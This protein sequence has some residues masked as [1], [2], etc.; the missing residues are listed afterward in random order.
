MTTSSLHHTQGVRG[1]LHQK[2]EHTAEAEIYHLH[3]TA[4]HRACP[5]CQSQGTSLVGTGRTRDIRGLCI[6]FK[7]R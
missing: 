7:K 6:G 4:A 5:R 2:T 3:P 1:F